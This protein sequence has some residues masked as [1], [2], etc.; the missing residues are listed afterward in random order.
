[1]RNVVVQRDFKTEAGLLKAIESGAGQGIGFDLLAA[2]ETKL[3]VLPPRVTDAIADLFS[4]PARYETASDLAHEAEIPVKQLYREF[5]KATLRSPK[6]L[7]ACAKTIHGYG[8]LRFTN[9]PEGA[10]RKKLGYSDQQCFSRQVASVLG[11]RPRELRNAL[12]PEELL[13]H[14]IEWMYRPSGLNRARRR[15]T[16]A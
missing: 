10:V 7:V 11:C 15:K 5:S 2:I 8:Y 3:A 12:S 14:L 16:I 1:L 6:K 4:R 9:Y 13:L